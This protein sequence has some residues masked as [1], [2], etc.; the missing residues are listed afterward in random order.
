MQIGV[1]NERARGRYGAFVGAM[2][3]VLESLDEVNKIIDRVKDDHATAGFTV[4]TRDEL[5]GYSRHAFADLDRLRST[6]KK[7]EAELMSREWRL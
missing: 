3:G 4:A 5:M 6:A 1:L 7:Y 2:D